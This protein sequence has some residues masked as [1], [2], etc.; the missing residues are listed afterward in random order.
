MGIQSSRLARLRPRR[1][2]CPCL[3]IPKTTTYTN[4]TIS[5]I[6][7]KASNQTTQQ[8]EQELKYYIPPVSKGMLHHVYDGDTIVIIATCDNDNTQTKYK[9]RV[10]F[11][12]IDCAELRS[13]DENEKKQAILARDKLIEKIN[14]HEPI[15]LHDVALDKYGRLLADVYQKNVCLNKWMIENKYAVPFMVRKEKSKFDGDEESKL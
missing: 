4:S 3:C 13:K 15:Y 9:F 8:T 7:T 10:R 12:S 14:P 5:T 2:L 6:T 11:A 1:N